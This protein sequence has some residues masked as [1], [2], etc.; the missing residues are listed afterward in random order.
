MGKKTPFMVD[1]S[2]YKQAGIDMKTGAPTRMVENVENLKSNMK[3][4]MRL[5]D[6]QDAVNRYKWYNLPCN[7]SS[8]EL[9]RLLYYKGQL[10]FFYFKE[11]DEFYFMPFALEGSIDFYGRYNKIHPVP[12]S[13]GTEDDKN[14]KKLYESQRALLSML[15]LNVVK[16][17][18]PLDELKEEDLYNSTVILW[19][20]SR[21]IG[22]NII[23][24]QEVND[25]LLEVIAEIP[26]FLR[27]ALIS[28][29]GVKGMRVAD[30]D[31]KN[32]VLIA[33]NQV[34]K[35]AL[36]GTPATPI[37]STIEIQELFDGPTG[38]AQEYLLAMQA[39][40]HFRLS[41]YGLD[42]G[43]LFEKKAHKLEEE[44]EMNN[45][46]VGLVYADGLAIRQNFC[47]IVNSI[48]GTSI[49][50][51]PAEA[52]LGTDVDGDGDAY[53]SNTDGQQSGVE[54]GT[55]NEEGGEQ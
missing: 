28:S 47:N 34:L 43:G 46:T 41:T 33:S 27:T 53:D 25:P 21:Q 4:I 24:R 8:E 9:E 38:K 1:P 44:Q 14:I 45:S 42:N 37:T 20:Y 12:M 19:D 13:S 30:A 10:C 55:P 54:G 52:V 50:C 6:E 5:I 11:L 31:A 40:E 26:C 48:W 32:E 2:I 18:K 39:L 7:I 36:E 16:A 17:I 29:T 15:K 23:P 22:Q 35:C 51:M 3:K 49:W